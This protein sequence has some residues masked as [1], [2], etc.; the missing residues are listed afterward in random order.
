MNQSQKIFTDFR[1]KTG[2][3]QVEAAKLFNISQTTVSFIERGLTNPSAE[4][5]L[6][7]LKLNKKSKAA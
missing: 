6:T 5:V 2:L 3:T 4:I 7:I 1:K